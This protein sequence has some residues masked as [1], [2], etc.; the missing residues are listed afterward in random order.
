M[1]ALK[2]KTWP[3]CGQGPFGAPCRVDIDIDMLHAAGESV[4][5]TVEA[6]AAASAADCRG[7]RI[8]ARSSVE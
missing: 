5:G 4:A 3:E 8:P 6:D 2:L 1:F 7:T